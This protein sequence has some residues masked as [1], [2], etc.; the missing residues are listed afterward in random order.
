MKEIIK[1]IAGWIKSRL[2]HVTCGRG[3]YIGLNVKIINS[4]GN[5]WQ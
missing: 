1:I 2:N 5:A 4:G 3:C